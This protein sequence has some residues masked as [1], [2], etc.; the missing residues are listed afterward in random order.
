MATQ[1]FAKKHFTLGY[2][3]WIQKNAMKVLGLLINSNKLLSNFCKCYFNEL[4]FD[5]EHFYLY[6]AWTSACHAANLD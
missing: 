2:Q 4:H 5:E 3:G 6:R 1:F